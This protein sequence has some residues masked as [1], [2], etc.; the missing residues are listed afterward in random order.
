MD[1]ALTDEQRAIHEVAAEV[2]P[3]LPADRRE[4]L[5]TAAAAGL[6]SAA[7]SEDVGGSGLGFLALHLMLETVGAAAGSLPLWE[8]VV[9]GALPVDRFG[10]A[11]QRTRL[12]EPVARGELVLTAGL[13]DDQPGD[14]G[15]PQTTATRHRDGWAVSGVRTLVPL[16]AEAHRILVP[17]R[18]DSGETAVLLVDPHGPGV[19]I[20]PQETLGLQPHCEVVLAGAVV[21][22]HDVLAGPDRGQQ[23]LDWTLLHA[24][25]GL[26]SLV[27]GACRGALE[28]SSAHV[29]T[30]EQFGRPLAAFQAVG[31]RLADAYVDTEAVLL[32]ALQAAWRLEAGL[33]ADN[34]VAIAAWWAAEAGHRVIHAAHHVHGGMGVDRS[35]PLPR[36]YTLVKQ[37]EV[38]LGGANE[39]L[40]RLGQAL[41]EAP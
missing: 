41:A 32:A 10:T 36:Y 30:R 33:H 40:A 26:A 39:H 37:A 35:Y 5:V 29:S 25:A 27:A 24:R 3:G 7:L 11:E 2:V 15:E 14:M 4:A 31:Q 28:L 34:E 20:H 13:L 38:V 18:A 12:L 23:V 8:T 17:V 1:F 21:A 19:E 22:D 9:L 16:A 6:L